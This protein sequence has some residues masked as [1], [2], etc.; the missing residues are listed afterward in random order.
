MNLRPSPL[1]IPPSSEPQQ[2]GQ[3]PGSSEKPH[4]GLS[5]PCL[6]RTENQLRHRYPTAQGITQATAQH[7][8]PYP[9]TVLNMHWYVQTEGAFHL[10]ASRRDPPRVLVPLHSRLGRFTR[11]SRQAEVAFTRFALPLAAEPA[12]NLFLPRNC[13]LEVVCGLAIDEL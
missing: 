5:F 2:A 7:N 12:F 10:P 8:I 3:I 6:L 9:A 11:T 4:P 13:R 1:S